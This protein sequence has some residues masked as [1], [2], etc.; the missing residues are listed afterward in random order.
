M[1]GEALR[2]QS[3]TILVALEAKTLELLF[4]VWRHEARFLAPQTSR[5][6]YYVLEK[7]LMPTRRAV[8]VKWI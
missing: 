8:F 6:F 2:L 4:M 7:D 3:L 5:I 1:L